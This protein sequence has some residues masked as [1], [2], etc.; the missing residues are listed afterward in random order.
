MQTIVTY[1]NHH[2]AV[3]LLLSLLTR[4]F[5]F[6]FIYLYFIQSAVKHERTRLRAKVVRTLVWSKQCHEDQ[7]KHQYCQKHCSSSPHPPH[8]NP[9]QLKILKKKNPEKVML[10]FVRKLNG[11]SN[12]LD[13][14]WLL[15]ML[16]FDNSVA[17]CLCPNEI[18]KF[19]DCSLKVCEKAVHY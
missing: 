15:R 2:I 19:G 10:L 4:P 12:T 5:F 11:L 6:L 13:A 7:S 9:P 18:G 1:G 16:Y 14:P 3:S 8:H 17:V